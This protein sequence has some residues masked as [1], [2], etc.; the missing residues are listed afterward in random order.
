[1]NIL[2]TVRKGHGEILYYKEINENTLRMKI[3]KMLDDRSYSDNAKEIAARF[4]DRPMKPLDTAVW[5]TEYVIRH[6]GAD[7]MKPPRISYIA[8]QML[9]VYLFLL[10]VLAVIIYVT[11]KLITCI[12]NVFGSKNVTKKQ[13]KS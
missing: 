7:F 11:L 13:K 9:D 12:M 3:N 1:M 4:K 5:W 2:D 6:K 10:G 8:Y